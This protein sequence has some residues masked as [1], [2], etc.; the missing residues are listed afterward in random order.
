MSSHVV[1]A[2]HCLNIRIHL[3]TKYTTATLDQLKQEQQVTEPFP[4][5]QF[6]LG[7]GGVKIEFNV[8]TRS[9][10]RQNWTITS[11]LHCH[12]ETVYS[13][14]TTN[15]SSFVVVH[16]DAIFEHQV[17]QKPDYS[18]RLN[19][20]LTQPQT[21]NLVSLPESDKDIPKEL[22]PAYKKVQSILGQS[23]EQLR[24]E[25]NT[26]LEQFKKEEEKRLQSDITHTKQEGNRLWSQ[27]IQ[28][29]SQTQ[30]KKQ[31]EQ[32][33]K[34]ETST[35]QSHHVRFSDKPI[36]AG[37]RLS[38]ALDE[39]SI[40]Q[41]RHV[42]LDHQTRLDGN[43]DL[44]SEEEE[45]DMFHLDEE[46]SEKED[47]EQE[48]EEQEEEEGEDR[49]EEK[50]TSAD[51]TTGQPLISAS[52]KK[53]ISEID[54]RFQWIK[55]KRNT[56]KYLARD[57]D[58]KTDRSDP[59]EEEE[60]KKGSE[61]TVSMFAT[62]VPITIH[63]ALD[64]TQEKEEEEDDKNT[65]LPKKRDILVSSFANFDASERLLS[66]QFPA[67]RR[68][69]SVQSTS[70]LRPQLESLVGK[71]LDTRGVSSRKKQP[72]DIESKDNSSDE[73]FDSSLPPHVWAAMN[74]GENE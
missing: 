18:K 44:S 3:A 29:S 72:E 68:R 21:S 38:F 42:K 30:D 47:D 4:G 53:S 9:T 19:I 69:K 8:L 31:Q 37:K 33:K 25:S 73:E 41:L 43:Q 35:G 71:S 17:K 64:E 13:V 12:M 45:E 20:L 15:P 70:L 63:Y 50:A 67:P 28:V 22:V 49:Q 51:R 36:P 11:C 46:L 55:K 74:S 66:A 6:E 60:E 10:K 61:S 57:F 23:I 24:I 48:E 34:A 59:Q 54:Q 58:L 40:H 27:M 52:L 2:C 1:Y 56:T 5:W 62:S 7:I 16:Q 26:R 65:L 32:P 39:Q 14:N